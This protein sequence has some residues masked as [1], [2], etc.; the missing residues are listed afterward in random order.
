MADSIAMLDACGLR[1]MSIRLCRK[2]LMLFKLENLLY[3]VVAIDSRELVMGFIV[4]M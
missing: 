1:D 2:F 4:V 3:Q